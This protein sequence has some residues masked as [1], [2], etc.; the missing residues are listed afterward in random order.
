M[1]SPLSVPPPVAKSWQLCTDSSAVTAAGHATGRNAGASY[2]DTFAP[3]TI[4][5]LFPAA[6]KY[7]TPDAVERFAALAI[8]TVLEE[9]LVEV[10]HVVD[11][12]VRVVRRAQLRD[13]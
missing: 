9:R 6:E 4:V 2:D 3:E 11:D 1:S 13:L 8:R 7:G 10:R 5:L 12:H